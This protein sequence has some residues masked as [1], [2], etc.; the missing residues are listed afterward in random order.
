MT[1]LELYLIIL[2]AILWALGGFMSYA[3]IVATENI[4]PSKTAEA[5]TIVFWPFAAL[6]AIFYDNNKR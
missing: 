3:G 1:T 2:C 6:Y 4:R 5:V